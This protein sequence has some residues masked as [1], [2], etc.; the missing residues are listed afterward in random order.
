MILSL[1]SKPNLRYGKI[2]F[3]LLS[4][5]M[6][7]VSGCMESSLPTWSNQ[8]LINTVGQAELADHYRL[9][10]LT[11]LHRRDL[12]PNQHQQLGRQYARIVGSRTH[13]PVIRQEVLSVIS[14]RYHH[15]APLWLGY[16]LINTTEPQLQK[17]IIVSIAGLNNKRALPYLVIFLADRID[18]AADP[19]VSVTI[20]TMEKTAN[21]SLNSILQKQLA[22]RKYVHSLPPTRTD[23]IS[24]E[25]TPFQVRMAAMNCLISR[26]DKQQVKNFL[27]DLSCDSDDYFLKQIQ[28]WI[29]QMDYLPHRIMHFWVGVWQCQK[30]EPSRYSGIRKR[31]D[32]LARREQYIFD[33]ADT[34]LLLEENELLL[35]LTGSQLK[36][37]IQQKLNSLRHLKRPA[38]Y[39][40]AQD[41]YR[42][43]FVDQCNLLSYTDLLRIWLLLDDLATRATHRHLGDLLARD[44][45]AELTEIGGLLYL[46]S[47]KIQWRVYPPGRLGGDN[48]YIESQSL[49]MDSA[50]C[51]ARWHCHV[52]TWRTVEIAGPGIDDVHYAKYV[53]SPI[54]IVTL[55]DDRQHEIIYNIDYLNPQ[56]VVIDLGVYGSDKK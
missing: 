44:R 30:I 51:L 9:Q 50:F 3:V 1:H 7:S 53:N 38:S 31:R 22:G 32:M 48:Q 56:G 42:E 4:L 39:P 14:D 18:D 6:L 26:T 43:D 34:Y 11:E 41:D 37:N 19:L 21:Q 17:Q 20:E 36:S 47:D 25:I 54:V 16:A 5:S 2:L 13:S 35:N 10:A 8:A 29:K 40:N 28:F 49:L 55:L 52:D 27:A 23:S 15:D 33:G 12:D 45:Q 24:S 46:Q